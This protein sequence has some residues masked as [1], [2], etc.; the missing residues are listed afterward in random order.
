VTHRG[1]TDNDSIDAWFANQLGTTAMS[2]F[3]RTMP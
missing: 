3:R 2:K 1:G